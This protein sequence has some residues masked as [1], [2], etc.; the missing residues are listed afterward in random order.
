VIVYDA[1]DATV[2]GG[3][4]FDRLVLLEAF[5]VDL[6]N[7]ADQVLGGGIATG[8]E[9]VDA[10][11][12]MASLRLVGST[13]ANLFLGGSGNDTLSGGGGN[14]T[15]HGNAGADSLSGE[16][17]NDTFYV[18][19]LDTVQEAVG[20]GKDVVYASANFTLTAGQEIEE[21]RVSG[22]AG[23]QLVGNE[24]GNEIYGGSGNDTLNGAGGADVLVGNGGTDLLIGGGDN[25]TYYVD[26]LDTVQ[27]AVG[28]GTDTVFTSVSFT[29]GAGQEVE[30]LRALSGAVGLRLTGN[31]LANTVLSDA[32]ADTLSGG[33]GN[34]TLS[35]GSGN[36][37]LFGDAGADSLSGGTGNDTYYVDA[38]DTVREAVGG[39]TDTV[40]ASAN[41]TLTAGQEIEVLQALA[42]AVG[43]RLTGN[44]L[45]N[46]ILGEALA[47]TLSGGGGND[48]LSG[49]GGND[50]LYGDAGAD[51]LSGGAGNDTYYVDALD[52]VV[53]AVGGG[54]DVVYATASF[55][56]TA[57]QE[58]E[59]F[60]VSGATG[61][62]LVGNERGGEIYGGSGNDT[63]NGA[64]GADVLI[65]NGGADLLI[66]GAD[67][68][69]FYVDALDTVQEAVG[70]GTDTVLASSNFTL[71]AGQEIEVLRALS[72][73]VGLRL[74]G[75]ELANTILGEALADTLSGGGGNDTLS[76]GG[77]NDILTGDAGADSLS[78]GTGNDTYYVD[79]LDTVQEAVGGGRDVVFALANFT[80][81]AG[82]EIEELR[83]A[84]GG[85][86]LV[87]NE[88]GNEIYGG[89]GNDTL[90]GAA[91]ADVLVGNGGADLL[92]GGADNDTFYVDALDT[93]QEA[94]GG[95]TD[96]VFASANFTLGAGQEIEVLRAMAGAVGLR[97]TGNELANTV[98]G[99][100]LA[101]TL[102]G[103]GGNDTLSSGGGN[104]ILTGDAGA[105]SLSGGTGNDTYY[106]D[107]LDTVRE[108]IGGGTDTVLASDNFTL[109][110]G[111]E[112]EVLQALAGAGGLRLTGNELANTVLGEALAD[113][114]SGGGGN[115]TLSGS[116]GNDVLYGD[117]GADSLSGGT[118]NDTYYVDGLDTVQEAVGGGRDVVFATVS[119]T[120]TAGQEIEELRGFGG[121]LQLVGNDRANEIYGG[122]GNDTLNG[123]A[124]ADV[125]VG[126]GG[127]DRLIGGA[128]VDTLYGGAGQD[129]FFLSNLAADRDVLSDF[130]GGTDFLQVS[131]SAFG[132]GLVVGS[133][134]GNQFLA[135]AT[136]LAGDADDRFIYNTSSGILFYDLDGAGAG[137]PVQIATLS[138]VPN[139]AASDF[140][141]VA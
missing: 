132:G 105:D 78:G 99:E 53:E 29:L 23:L 98:L 4:D 82:Q 1:A 106:V 97:L 31:E 84:G 15:L 57:G 65:G 64:A 34:D 119:F 112:I 121:G 50:V 136:G 12:L 11:A 95:G 123:A 137:G 81:G 9:A 83:G 22:A 49:S 20:G 88:R 14:D 36:D 28:G 13:G 62:Q 103:G 43:L 118:G 35:G 108:A 79:A 59:E 101:D 3:D 10:S 141:L 46:T 91:G 60:R 114:L 67:N 58:V 86:Q 111:Q 63:L 100:A 92:I 33:A 122:S 47:D 37:V 40:L 71:G 125:L 135:N 48:T 134:A 93:V 90:N 87:G 51:S 102:S 110:A 16:A 76:G 130:V 116:G 133:L 44:E 77:G 72:G 139:L 45:A 109:T 55:T 61:L 56:L 113:T 117:A 124:G 19:T 70:G 96:A 69:T 127:A 2:T 107:G 128:G 74:A 66:G 30:V 42:G 89:S 104:D 115:D 126:N 7:A 140:I 17:G 120:L 21:F 18:D 41:F 8:F 38:L 26:G 32:G 138:G 5:D 131:V 85:L 54:R 68:D 24:R 73:A 27:E 75:N 52:T 94:V 39:G 129:V 25:D 6:G 80:L